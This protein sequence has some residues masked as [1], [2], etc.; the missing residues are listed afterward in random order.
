MT[1]LAAFLKVKH[2]FVEKKKKKSCAVYEE[3]IVSNTGEVG[4]G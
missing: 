4:F 2:D 3:V 1:K